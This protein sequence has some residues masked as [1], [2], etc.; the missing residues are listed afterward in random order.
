MRANPPKDFRKL[1]S[2]PTFEGIKQ[3]VAK[4]YVGERELVPAPDDTWSI[5]GKDGQPLTPVVIETKRG[6][7]FG[8]K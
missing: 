4:F 3:A 1:A 8:V 2:S 6:F 5:H 7:Y